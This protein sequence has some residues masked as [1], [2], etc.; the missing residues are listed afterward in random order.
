MNKSKLKNTI[1]ERLAEFVNC[2]LSLASCNLFNTLGYRSE[3]KF[4]RFES[5]AEF[6]DE[7]KLDSNGT[8]SEQFLL[9]QSK[10]IQILF[11]LTDSEIKENQ[12]DHQQELRFDR[13][14]EFDQGREQCFLFVSVELIHQNYSRS[15]YGVLARE[16]NKR[17]NAPAVVLFRARKFISIAFVNRRK[18][19]LI[20]DREV[21]GDVSIIKDIDVQAPHRAHVDI[22][23]ELSLQDQL[24]WMNNHEISQNFDGLL[25]SWLVK[26]DT[27]ELNRVFFT[28]LKNWFDWTVKESTF[29]NDSINGEIY[30]TRLITRLLF[31]WFVKEKSLIAEELFNEKKVEKLLNNYSRRGDSYYRVVLENLFFAVLNTEMEKRNFSKENGQHGP[32]HF[33]YQNEMNCPEEMLNLFAQTPFINGGLFDCLD[34][35]ENETYIDCFSDD[36][37]INRLLS[38]PNKLFFDESLGLIPL[39]NNY[40]FTVE[41]STPIEKEIALDPELLGEVFENLLATINPET[42]KSLRK[43]TGSFYTPRKIVEYM[44]D[45]ALVAFISKQVL[46][47]DNDRG[48]FWIARLRYLMNY[49]GDYDD[50]RELFDESEKKGIVKVLSK[51][52][53]IDPA[54]G[55]GAFPMGMLHKLTLI[56]NRIDEDNRLWK[57][58]QLNNLKQRISTNTNTTI[59]REIE[60]HLQDTLDTFD[61]Y[62]ANF[63]RKLYLIKNNLFGVDIQPIACQITKLRFFISLAIEQEFKE[64][65]YN[66]GFTPLPNLETRFIAADSLIGLNEGIVN[67]DS[68]AQKQPIQ[69]EMPLISESDHISL[70]LTKIKDLRD[71][72]FTTNS[73]SEKFQCRREEEI[74][75]Q[76][77]L[78]EISRHIEKTILDEQRRIDSQVSVIPNKQQQQQF[79][80]SAE[81][82][83]AKNKER[84]IKSLDYG[85]LIANWNPY[86][87]NSNA[88]FF[89]PGWM[90]G[91]SEGF[92]IVIGNPPYIQLQRNAPLKKRLKPTNFSVMTSTGDVY[93]LFIEKGFE[94]VTTRAV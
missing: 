47:E 6:I 34:R 64:R 14:N 39:L 10:F 11:Q 9:E 89:D 79:R 46:P 43:H 33:H 50:A 42:K 24:Q 25:K 26:L 84:V 19:K 30:V 31:I 94:L 68:T 63:A 3:I 67:L 51:I 17:F 55:S 75:R 61:N 49:S 12:K 77:L 54:V 45:E 74:C 93:Q 85:P 5:S 15:N 16:I 87:Q 38:F 62:S 58:A 23:A 70:I 56:L 41:E 36:V 7:F 21:L 86:D 59:E 82:A 80:K 29:P 8:R 52:K 71:K 92:D 88:D 78:E 27:Q 37:R 18:H 48:E 53:I 35:S 28:K 32:S 73:P 22:L 65:K 44:I 91:I 13:F 81:L 1:K 60:K 83:I 90:F 69:T 72:Y 4:S 66:L 57:D 2:E 76:Q 20:D 40:K